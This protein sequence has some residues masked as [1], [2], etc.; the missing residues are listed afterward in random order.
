MTRLI[1]RYS[2]RFFVTMLAFPTVPSFRFHAVV[3]RILIKKCISLDSVQ[4]R[5][6]ADDKLKFTEYVVTEIILLFSIFEY[7]QFVSVFK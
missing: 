1:L 5:R 2:P 7:L 6:E 4:K 3:Y